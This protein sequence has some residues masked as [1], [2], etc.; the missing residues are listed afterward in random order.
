MSTSPIL[1]H[2]AF[3]FIAIK[4]GKLMLKDASEVNEGQG[5]VQ[6]FFFV[7]LES[8]S[9]SHKHSST[10]LSDVV[11]LNRTVKILI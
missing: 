3:K 8:L 5:V 1:L 10:F 7:D 4:K 6:I 2:N 9:E 11:N